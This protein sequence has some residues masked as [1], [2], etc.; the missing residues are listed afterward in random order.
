MDSL[1]TTVPSGPYNAD[2][3][4]ILRKFRRICE[5]ISACG[6]IRDLPK[7]E[8]KLTVEHLPDGTSRTTYPQ[9]DKDDFLAFLTHF[10]KLVA[11][12]EATNVRRVLNIIGKY[13]DEIERTALKGI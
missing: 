6:F 11:Q 8:H 2:E 9:Y 5:E 7:Q 13:A 12:G 3:L 10:R 1:S 4:A